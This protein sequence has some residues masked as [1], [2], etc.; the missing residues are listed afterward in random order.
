MDR[1]TIAEAERHLAALVNRV[2]SEGVSIELEQGDRVVAYLTPALPQSPLKAR[3]LAAFL[4]SL[5]K[6]GEDADSFSADLHDPS[7]VT[8]GG[9]LMRN[10]AIHSSAPSTMAISASLSP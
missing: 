7:R 10:F 6:L 1:V 9:S 2:Y 4:Q 3:D 5:P 8:H